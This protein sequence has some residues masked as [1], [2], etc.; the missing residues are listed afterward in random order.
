MLPQSG[1]YGYRY[2]D[3]GGEL[4]AKM[5]MMLTM[6]MMRMKTVMVTDDGL[7]TEMFMVLTMW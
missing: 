1:E 5:M 2:G 7:L 4:V 3:G 6:R